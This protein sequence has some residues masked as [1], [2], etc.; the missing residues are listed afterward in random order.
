M[1]LATRLLLANPG[2]Q[3]SNALS[4]SLTTPGAKGVFQSLASDFESIQTFTMTN[5]STTTIDFTSIPST[6]KALKM[7]VIMQGTADGQEIYAAFNND[8][9]GG[10]YTREVMYNTG[11]GAGTSFAQVSQT[12]GRSFF[13]NPVGTST[14]PYTYIAYELHLPD[15]ALTN[16]RKTSIID[17]FQHQATTTGAITQHSG[18]WA[19]TAAINR[20]TLTCLTGNF[21]IY[22]QFALY[23]VK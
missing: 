17:G 22:S 12:A 9:T 10:N 7:R 20:I 14:Y 19:S 4:G 6:Y 13:Y 2:A 5:N 1:S 11:S 21:A 3:V 16:K 15:Y 8:T 23:G 18:I